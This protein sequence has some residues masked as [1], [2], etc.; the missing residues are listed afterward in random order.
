ML[1][2]MRLESVLDLSVRSV[3]RTVSWERSWAK[4]SSTIWSARRRRLH[5]L[6]PSGAS[7]QAS[8]ISSASCSLSS[9]RSYSRSGDFR[10]TQPV[11]P[12]SQKRCRIPATVLEATSSASAVRSSVQAG[13]FGPSS[14]FSRTRT[15]VCSAAGRSPRPRRSRR[16]DRCSPVSST[17]VFLVGH[18]SLGKSFDG[19]LPTTYHVE[20]ADS[21]LTVQ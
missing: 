16:W 19:Q 2:P 17:R 21:R 1:V 9:L 18:G 5:R 15:R 14:T 7:E 13:P 8:R 20:T 10:S 12:R 6:R 11:R 3:C 4:P